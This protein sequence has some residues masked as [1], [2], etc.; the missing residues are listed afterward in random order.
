MSFSR[1]YQGRN[2]S[3]HICRMVRASWS[4]A[5]LT[6]FSQTPYT[7]LIPRFVHPQDVPRCFLGVTEYLS[8]GFEPLLRLGGG[9]PKLD[10]LP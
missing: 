1:Q 10:L 6:H 2:V 7:H 3:Q 4:G 8:S 5:G 9:G